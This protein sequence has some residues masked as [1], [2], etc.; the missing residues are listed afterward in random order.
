[1]KK[2]PK[3]EPHTKSRLVYARSSFGMAIVLTGFLYGRSIG[4]QQHKRKSLRLA[5]EF[6]LSPRDMVYL[7]WFFQSHWNQISPNTND[8]KTGSRTQTISAA[9]VVTGISRRRDCNDS[10]FASS[11]FHAGKVSQR[12]VRM[13]WNT[14][15]PEYF[16]VT[17]NYPKVIAQQVS[18]EGR[19]I[20]GYSK[21]D[22]L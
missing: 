12:P 20:G 7:T 10:I 15:F 9:G 8:E 2:L 18:V 4:F 5:R 13:H 3:G 1:M 19:W 14:R 16:T 11:F 21:I 22:H 6:V 17:D